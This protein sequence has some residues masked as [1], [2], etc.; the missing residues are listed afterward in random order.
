MDGREGRLGE[1]SKK[2]KREVEDEDA[3]DG[4]KDEEED[5]EVGVDG[6]AQKPKAKKKRKGVDDA[7]IEVD[8]EPTTG[9]RRF[10]LFVGTSGSDCTRANIL[11]YS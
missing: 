9:N 2:R 11:I 1:M 7:G 8:G 10:I 4:G 3:K 6:G 5:K